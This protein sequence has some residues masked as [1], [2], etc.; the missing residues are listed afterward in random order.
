MLLI[1]LIIATLCLAREVT[2][3][4]ANKAPKSATN[5]CSVPFNLP[6]F[7]HK[8]FEPACNIHDVCYGCVSDF[9]VILQ[10]MTHEDVRKCEKINVPVY[11]FPHE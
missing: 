3:D 4:C 6:Y 9:A 7:Y 5:G 2:G 11:Q 8:T 10:K 1:A